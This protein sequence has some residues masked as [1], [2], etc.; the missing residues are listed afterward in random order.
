[1]LIMFK[2]LGPIVSKTSLK[3]NNVEV[4]H[5]GLKMGDYFGQSAQGNRFKV[6]KHK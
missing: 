1:M 4:T 3:N 6:F 2:T 5:R